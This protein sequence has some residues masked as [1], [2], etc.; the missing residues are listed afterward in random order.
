[1]PGLGTFLETLPLETD[2]LYLPVVGADERGIDVR[3]VPREGD[4][5]L[6][7]GVLLL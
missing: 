2:R 4:V 3:P 7:G 6:G 5:V 1:M